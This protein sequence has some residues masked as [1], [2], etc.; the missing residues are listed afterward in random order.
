[1]DFSRQ[2]CD[3]QKFSIANL[4]TTKKMVIENFQSPK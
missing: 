3:D 4:T 2:S 1:M